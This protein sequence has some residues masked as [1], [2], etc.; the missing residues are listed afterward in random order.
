MQAMDKRMAYAAF[1]LCCL[2]QVSAPSQ[3]ELQSTALARFTSNYLYRGYT[4]SADHGVAQ[5]HIGASH[6]SGVYGGTWLSQ[7][8][9]GGAEFELIPYVGVQRRFGDDV[10]LDGV[11][12]GY[13]YESPVFGRNANYSEVTVSADWRGLVT[14]RLS[15][16]Y[17]SYGSGHSSATGEFTGRYPVSDV[18]EITGGAGF[19][20]MV[21]VTGYDVMFW[22]IGLRYFLGGHVVVD[23][24]YVDNVH[25]TEA[26]DVQAGLRFEQ[27]EVSGRAVLSISIGY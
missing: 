16:A 8:D 9:F 14:G 22:S 10:Q 13:L 17:D 24:R 25:L 6:R 20:E 4:K 1:T 26:H 27:A 7:V 23:M 12:S 18:L 2:Q 3:A 21:D 5:A 11:L 15:V 19:S